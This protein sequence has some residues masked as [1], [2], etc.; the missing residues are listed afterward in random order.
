MLMYCTHQPGSLQENTGV[1]IL[2]VKRKKKPGYNEHLS[3]QL[4]YP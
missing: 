1:T 4:M 2:L 3:K